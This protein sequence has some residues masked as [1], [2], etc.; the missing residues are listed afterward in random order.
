MDIYE[1]KGSGNITVLLA[2]IEAGRPLEVSS[3]VERL[4]PQFLLTRGSDM[5]VAV[6]VRGESMTP[7]VADGDWCIIDR[8]RQPQNGDVVL[9]RLGDGYTL[10]TLEQ[11]HGLYLVPNNDLYETKKVEELDQ[12]GIIGVVT[13]VIHP[14]V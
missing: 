10:K 8:E 3:D 11:R 1:I 4:D 2:A 5:C 6:R 13:L 14:L 7:L 9:A 12:F